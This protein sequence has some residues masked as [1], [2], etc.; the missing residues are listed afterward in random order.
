MPIVEEPELPP[1][2]IERGAGR[3]HI[4]YL[5]LGTFQRPG[6]VNDK[7]TT[8]DFP[9]VGK[10]ASAHSLFSP[11]GRRWRKAPDEG[12]EA[13]DSDVCRTTP[14]SPRSARHF[15]PLGRRGRSRQTLPPP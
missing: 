7:Q 10:G 15:S 13:I 11:A 4:H 14:S 8:A 6:Q 1:T 5:S 9:G 12:G 2:T 3:R